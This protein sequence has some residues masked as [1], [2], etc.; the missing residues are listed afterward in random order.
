M[1]DD[2]FAPTPARPVRVYQD[3]VENDRLA[4]QTR[5]RLVAEKTAQNEKDAKQ[6]IKI[7]QKKVEESKR[8]RLI[9]GKAAVKLKRAF[10]K[11]QRELDANAEALA[12][13]ARAVGPLWDG[14]PTNG[15]QEAANSGSIPACEALKADGG[16]FNTSR[17][18]EG[19]VNTI[20]LHSAARRGD[21]TLADTLLQGKADP[22]LVS[23]DRSPLILA[24]EQGMTKLVETLVRARANPNLVMNDG[25]VSLHTAAVAGH[26]ETVKSLLRY[27]ALLEAVYDGSSALFAAANAGQ[28]K[29][30]EVLLD[31]KAEVDAVWLPNEMSALMTAALQGHTEVVQVLCHKKADMNAMS[32]DG[33]TAAYIAAEAGKDGPVRAL[34]DERADLSMGRGPS[35]S[36]SKTGMTP[37][38]IAKALGHDQVLEAMGPIAR[39]YFRR[40]LRFKV[41]FGHLGH[42]LWDC[43]EERMVRALRQPDK[44]IRAEKRALVRRKAELKRIADEKA[45]EQEAKKRALEERKLK[46]SPSYRR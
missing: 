14:P 20:P 17:E 36:F 9:K 37:A 43:M 41:G 10:I 46:Q 28:A 1:S 2:P 27:K 35:A 8:Q 15:L 22:N 5:Q 42:V 24:A 3:R 16:D 34:L 39:P 45:A 11:E 29:G 6:A 18:K 13:V 19:A 25:L 12:K 33:K 21:V 38:G 7:H 4:T 30:V 26:G 32:K 31:N 44:N 40:A 23:G